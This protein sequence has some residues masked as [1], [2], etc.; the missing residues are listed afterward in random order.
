[1]IYERT[2]KGIFLER[3]NR[4]A[5]EIEIG[6]RTEICHVRNTGR[7]RELFIKGTDVIVQKNDAPARKTSYDLI[8]VYKEKNGKKE[9]VNVD[10]QIPN[11]AAQEWL[12]KG[13]FLAD[14]T[15]LKREKTFGNSRFDFYL[16]WGSGHRAFMEVKGVTLDIDGTAYFPDAPTERGLKHVEEL[17]ECI[18]QGY[19]AYLLFVVQ[20]KGIR[21]VSPNMRTH[22]EFGEALKRAEACGVRL[23]AYDCRVE[24]DAI[25][26][27]QPLPVI[28]L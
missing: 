8:A 1:M 21:A 28:L 24:E 20:M 6:G 22:P 25:T 4:F 9:L 11:S 27:D 10:S 14:L 17:C 2:E 16:E 23:L 5:A 3:K 13:G 26:I 18:R 19:E 15:L 12:E 7:C